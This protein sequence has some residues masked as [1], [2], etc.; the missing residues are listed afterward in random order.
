MQTKK[1]E[2][3]LLRE[4]NKWKRSETRKKDQEQQIKRDREAKKKGCFKNIPST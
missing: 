2:K 3:T 1:K 4:G